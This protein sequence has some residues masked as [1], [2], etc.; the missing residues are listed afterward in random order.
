MAMLT[1]RRNTGTAP[2]GLPATLQRAVALFALLALLSVPAPA[3]CAAA[4]QPES[5]VQGAKTVRSKNAQ[6]AQHRQKA[7]AA[8]KGNAVQAAR[9][10]PSAPVAPSPS[11]SGQPEQSGQPMQSGQL[12]RP[13]RVAAVQGVDFVDNNTALLGLVKGLHALGLVDTLPPD[14][15]ANMGIAELWDWLAAHAGGRVIFVPGGFYDGRRD[16][17]R[18]KQNR[19]E[20]R[21]RIDT[22]GDIDIIVAL[23]TPGGVDMATGMEPATVLVM[24]STNPVKAGIVKG[25]E[26]SGRDTVLATVEGSPYYTQLQVFHS[27]F[28]FRRLGICYENS[29]EWRSVIAY[30]E[31][32][33]AAAQLGFELVAGLITDFTQDDAH[34]AA[35]RA[36]CHRQIATKVDAMYLTMGNGTSRKHLP[37]LM[38]PLLEARLPTLSQGGEKDVEA[39][40]LL[41]FHSTN[42]DELGLFAAN[43]FRQLLEGKKAG[44]IRQTFSYDRD[45][46]LNLDTAAAIGWDAPLPVL[47]IMDRVYPRQKP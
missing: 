44:E 7:G 39:G 20:L 46:A 26:F 45:I 43:V 35:L 16:L 23:G 15:A 2:T 37:Q 14:T 36:E 9:P 22:M 42:Y 8:Q 10:A 34:N 11:P 33:R 6:S 17:A 28:G 38:A 19:D 29:A 12:E 5:P 4:G 32:R 31:I 13:V 24:D 3:W 27:I 18:R 41:G 30:D 1:P 25:R 40:V 21:Q 47:A